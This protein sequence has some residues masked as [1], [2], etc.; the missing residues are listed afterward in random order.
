MN[1]LLIK[2][3]RKKNKEAFVELMENCQ[4]QL[5][6]I[7]LVMLGNESDAS[8]AMQDTILSCW[9]KMDTLRQNRYFQTWLTRIL[10]NH[11][12]SILRERKRCV[13]G[14]RIPEE[15]VVSEGYDQVEWIQMLENLS[16]KNRV[17]VLLYYGE[18][19]KVNEIAEILEISSSAVKSRLAAAR[20]QLRI[21]YHL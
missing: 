4:Q 6:K 7:A 2:K 18:G 16:E 8:D 9:E 5:Y 17:V 10:I 3:A 11:C 21:E 13:F 15:G 1:E 12:N 14:E 19:F 20:E